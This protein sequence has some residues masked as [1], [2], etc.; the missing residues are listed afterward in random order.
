[1]MDGNK[2]PERLLALDRLHICAG[3]KDIIREFGQYRWDG[4]SKGQDQVIKE[5][6]HAMDDMRYFVRTAMKHTLKELRRR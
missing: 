6:D 5:Y 4:K 2:I 1:M 3:C